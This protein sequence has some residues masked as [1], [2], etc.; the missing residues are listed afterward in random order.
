MAA[1]PLAGVAVRPVPVG[2]GC[3]RGPDRRLGTAATAWRI[4]PGR[5]VQ[6]GS[7]PGLGTSG[8]AARSDRSAAW[9]HLRGE[10]PR[11]AARVEGR[12]ERRGVRTA[13]VPPCGLEPVGAGLEMPSAAFQR[14]S[15]RLR[16][17]V[18]RDAPPAGRG[19]ARSSSPIDR[20]RAG[21]SSGSTRQRRV[22]ARRPRA[23]W[24]PDTSPSRARRPHRAGA[25][26]SRGRSGTGTSNGKRAGALDRPAVSWTRALGP[27]VGTRLQVR[28]RRVR[29]QA[30]SASSSSGSRT[31]QNAARPIRTE[32]QGQLHDANRTR[33][34]ILDVETGGFRHDGIDSSLSLPAS[35]ILHASLD[36]QVRAARQPAVP[37][38]A[39]CAGRDRHGGQLDRPV[40]DGP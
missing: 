3:G 28:P 5:C 22:E 35:G 34:T 25:S 2:G 27:P 23:V 9:A 15:H 20:A 32:I 7:I 18:D 4:R 11:T 37:G 1:W 40:Q 17:R 10:R 36:E 14:A 31:S 26:S 24:T 6:A 19:P 33:F 21:A 13:A 29:R 8:S 39:Q 30:S 38:S 16:S 12:F